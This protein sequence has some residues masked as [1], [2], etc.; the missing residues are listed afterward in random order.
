MKYINH[1]TAILAIA[2]LSVSC[3][4]FPPESYHGEVQKTEKINQSE[5]LNSFGVLK[6]YIDRSANPLFMLGTGVVVDDFVKKEA[7]YGLVVTNFDEVTV[8]NMNHGAITADEGE[9]DFGTVQGAVMTAVDGSLSV[10]GGP[11]VTHSGQNMVYLNSLIAPTRIPIESESGTTKFDLEDMALGTTL[12]MTGNGS[13]TVVTDPDGVSGNVLYIGDAANSSYPKI[14]ITLPE[15]RKLGDYVHVTIDFRGPGSGGLYGQGMRMAINDL[16]VTGGWGGPSTFGCPGDVWGR[17]LIKLELSRLNLTEA[18]R[19]LTSFDLIIGSQTSAADYYIDNVSMYY[20]TTVSGTIEVANFE[21]DALDTSYPMFY[22]SGSNG[23]GWAKVENDPKGGAGKV[24]HIGGPAIQAH[25]KFH[26]VLPEGRRLGEMVKLTMDMSATGTTGLYGGG[27]RLGIND[28]PLTVF[29]SAG[30]FGV[31]GDG[32]WGRGLVNMEFANLNLTEAQKQLT[33]FDVIA[34]SAT[35]SGDYWIDNVSIFWESADKEIVIPQTPERIAD[36]L[37]YAMNRWIAGM[38]AATEGNVKSWDVIKEP[39]N[40]AG[41]VN[42]GSNET[43]FFWQDYLGEEGYARLAVK[44]TR[45]H[46]EGDVTLFVNETG[47]LGNSAKLEGLV[48]Y[49]AR[50]ESDGVTKI[51]GISTPLSLTLKADPAAQTQQQQDIDDLFE[52]LAATGRLIR[53]NDLGISLEGEEGAN[54]TTANATYAQRVQLGD[55]YEAIV[56]SYFAKIPAAQRYGITAGATIE[57][58][59]PRG[60]WGTDY[61]RTPVYAGFA[62]GLGAQ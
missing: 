26:V 45:Q 59:E 21:S 19:A 3:A 43:S 39:V 17:G 7:L 15:G 4:E 38:M 46:N 35:G 50:V 42:G 5:Y 54:V 25:A 52:A 9:M 44:L 31:P 2:V 48:D 34:G 22:D 8:P 47:L 30:E 37:T 18:Q 57:G 56:K 1:F 33:E 61:N 60:L 23:T 51:D 32:T 24:L 11:L 58:S 6:S 12:P 29:M 14:P 20:E 40:D 10:F 41:A 27:M 13:A 16:P 49:I 53:I 62:M 55:F 28:G 36:T